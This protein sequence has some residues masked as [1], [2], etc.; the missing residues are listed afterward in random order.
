LGHTDLVNTGV[1][2]WSFRP[3][4]FEEIMKEYNLWLKKKINDKGKKYNV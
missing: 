2:C 4:S 1:D 3:V